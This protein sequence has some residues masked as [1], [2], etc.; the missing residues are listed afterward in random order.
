MLS[1]FVTS[2]V[3]LSESPDWVE[4]MAAVE[5]ISDVQIS[6]LPSAKQNMVPAE[7]CSKQLNVEF[8]RCQCLLTLLMRMPEEYLCL[9]SSSLYI[10]YILNLERYILTVFLTFHY[11][12]YV[13]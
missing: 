7:S 4:A 9:K 12:T 2:R 13:S 6:A 1:I 10:T 8:A 5:N 3:D 11:Q